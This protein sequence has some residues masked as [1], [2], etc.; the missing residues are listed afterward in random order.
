MK[1]L[2]VTHFFP[3]P[4]NCGGRIGYLNPIKYLSRRNQVFLVS[5]GGEGDRA[6]VPEMKKYCADVHVL[7]IPRWR[8]QARLI[9]GL[10]ANPP[11]S[12]AKFFDARFGQLIQNCIQT[13]DID[14]VELQH[15]NTSAYLPFAA[16]VP[17]LLREHNVEYKVWER[18]AQYASGILEQRYVRSCA[19]RVREYEARMALRFARCITVSLADAEYLRAVAPA[20]RI[21]TIP[22]GV[23]TEYFFPLAASEDPFSM[24]LTGSF[25]WRP[26]QHNLRVLLEQIFPAVRERVP[27]ATLTIVGAGVPDALRRLGESMT[28]V[29]VI[30]AVPDVRDYVRRATLVL[31]YLQSGGGIALKVL[32]AMAMR[33]PVLSNALGIEGIELEHGRDVFVA[34]GVQGFAEAAAALLR[35]GGLRERLA[36]RGYDT[37]RRKYCWIDL[38]RRFEEIYSE[39]M[40]EP[41][42]R[43]QR[44]GF[45][46]DRQANYPA[47]QPMKG[48][49]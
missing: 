26:K 40:A 18:H 10:I 23:D 30:G 42:S 35:D 22:S 25:D 28:G 3:Y 15:L 21:E 14:I 1:I 4:P 32:E 16:G 13:Y 11:G 24:V 44:P 33:K 9:R 19:T 34:D 2:F 47:P 7:T 29:R 41:R 8:Q 45:A 38:A 5:L 12:A 27:Q 43:W 17:T 39:V 6:Y 36:H 31:N 49:Q 20:A 48:I 37:I 46:L